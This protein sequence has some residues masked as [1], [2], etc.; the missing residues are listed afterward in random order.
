MPEWFNSVWPV[1]VFFLGGVATQLT[2]W[3]GH[4][5]ERTT[6]ERQR[7]EDFELTHLV[8][9]STLLR[10]S[11]ET[12]FT[13]AILKTAAHAVSA[14]VDEATR[15][16]LAQQVIEA[17]N[18]SGVARQ[19]LGAQIGFILQ[20]PIRESV[21]SAASNLDVDY[22]NVMGPQTPPVET[23]GAGVKPA[24]AALASRVREIYAGR[25]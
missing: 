21:Q 16:G 1:A 22:V 4:R 6:S 2:G 3:L 14:Q 24:H 13:L 10:D 20:N 15:Q 11:Q 5:R 12:L 23:L 18:A 17:S 19:S 8:E 9:V 7:R 25:R